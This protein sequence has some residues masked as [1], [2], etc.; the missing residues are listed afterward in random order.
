MSDLRERYRA[1]FLGVAVGDT[2]GYQVEFDSVREIHR[3]YGPTGVR[4]FPPGAKFSD[5]TQN[6]IA[7]AEGLLDAGG[8]T[9]PDVVMP[10][11]ARHFV[12]WSVSPDN[13]R[14][15]GGTCM[16]GCAALARGVPWR[17]SGVKGS[18]GCGA[19]MRVSPIGLLYDN[20]QAITDVARATAICTHNH[21]DAL[22]AAH[23]AALAVRLLLGNVE[24]PDL[25]GHLV[26]ETSR[27]AP[28]WAAM[29]ARVPKALKATRRGIAPHEIQR[30]GREPWR[31]GESWVADEAVASALFCFLLAHERGEGFRE[32]I[33]YGA[34]TDGD[35]DSIAAICGSMAGAYWGLGGENG[36]LEEWAVRVEKSAYLT[37]LAD[38]LHA[39]ASP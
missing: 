1:C 14:A 5:D 8:S 27:G 36:V 33:L 25:L 17:E 6:T 31:L 32:A 16:A 37:D 21:P 35:S 30:H 13:N 34:N 39:Q 11:V 12:D 26:G 7:L 15:P 18:R 4:D 9:D 24:P 20:R 38:R 28:G 10:H 3:R 22:A 19:A 2:L 23:G 29:L